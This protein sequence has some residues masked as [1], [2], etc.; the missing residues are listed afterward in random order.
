MGQKVKLIINGREF[1]VNAQSAEDEQFL[2][3]TADEMSQYIEAYQNRYPG[4]Q[5]SD[6]LTFCSLNA[7]LRAKKYQRLLNDID[8]DCKDLHSRTT[9]YLD[10]LE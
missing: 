1:M 4:K 7:F 8:E 5:L 6:I 3:E 2:R 10:S 9:A